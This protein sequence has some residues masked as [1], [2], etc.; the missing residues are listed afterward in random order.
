MLVLLELCW[1]ALKVRQCRRPPLPQKNSKNDGQWVEPFVKFYLLARVDGF[2][3]AHLEPE[4]IALTDSIF[5][6]VLCEAKVLGSSQPIL[7]AGNFRAS[8]CQIPCFAKL[9]SQGEGVEL[10][11][12]NDG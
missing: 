10:E 6:A 12:A 4:N 7:I 3:G 11:A 5:Q 9:I 2:Q 1:S 8:P